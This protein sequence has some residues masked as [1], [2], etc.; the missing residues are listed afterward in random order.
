M[1]QLAAMRLSTAGQIPQEIVSFAAPRVGDQTFSQVFQESVPAV[2]YECTDDVV[3]H[4]PADPLLVAILGQ[5]PLI[6]PHFQGLQPWIYVS[7]GT[8]RFIDWNGRIED[9][10]QQLEAERLARLA[11]LIIQLRFHQIINDHRAGCG[12]GYMSSVCPGI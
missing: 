8:L 9:D 7:A 1:A 3:P 12:F 2:R 11:L 6:G 10:S 5:F 4:L